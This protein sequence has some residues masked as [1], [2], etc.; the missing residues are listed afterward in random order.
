MPSGERKTVTYPSG[1]TVTYEYNESQATFDMNNGFM[2]DAE[3]PDSVSHNLQ[4]ITDSGGR[5]IDLV[6]DGVYTNYQACELHA[7][8]LRLRPC[9]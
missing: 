8:A 1:E 3:K 9:W 2:F 5:R 4:R 7:A 6:W